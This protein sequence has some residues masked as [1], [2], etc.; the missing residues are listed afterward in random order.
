[1]NITQLAQ[2][3]KGLGELSERKEILLASISKL[4]KEEERLS[5]AV[6]NHEAHTSDLRKLENEISIFN[7]RIIQKQNELKI[8]IDEYDR[9]DSKKIELEKECDLLEILVSQKKQYIFDIE[10]YKKIALRSHADLLNVEK[11]I[12]ERTKNYSDIIKKSQELVESFK[13]KVS[14][15]NV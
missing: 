12:S 3:K 2:N 1:M 4:G 6:K 9:L 7:T 11:N 14:Q 10:N 15:F 8:L 5:N 13:K